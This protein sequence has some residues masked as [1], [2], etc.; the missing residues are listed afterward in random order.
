MSFPSVLLE[1]CFKLSYESPPGL[2]KNFLRT[3]QSVEGG[4]G[5]KSAFSFTLAYF[6]ALVQERRTYIPQGWSKAY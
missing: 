6:H 1:T 3:Y 4:S 5:L 2:K